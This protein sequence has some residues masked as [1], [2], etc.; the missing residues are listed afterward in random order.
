M[1]DLIPTA[2]AAAIIGC[3]VGH[4]SLLFRAGKLAGEK[5]TGNALFVSRKSVERFA[6]MPR[7]VGRPRI[8]ESKSG[9]R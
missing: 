8:C 9:I 5:L 2:K 7:T 4:V 1:K 3:T 6:K